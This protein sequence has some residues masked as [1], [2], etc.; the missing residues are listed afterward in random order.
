MVRKGKKEEKKKKGGRRGVPDRASKLRRELPPGWKTSDEDEVLRRRV[1]A[2][3]E[4]IEVR[5]LEPSMHVYGSFVAVTG[6]S[7]RPHRIELRSVDERE[8]TCDCPDFR[9]NGLGTC[10]HVEAV[11]IYAQERWPRHYERAHGRPSPL[12]EV[13]LSRDEDGNHVRVSWPAGRPTEA[14]RLLEPFFGASG[15][16]LAEPVFGVPAVR[17]AVTEFPLR[18]RARIRIAVD[19]DEWVEELNRRRRRGGRREA[20]LKDAAD[21]KRAM[22]PLP[23]R[24]YSYQLEGMLHLAFGERAMLA[25]DMGLGKTIQAIAAAELLRRLRGIERVL[26]VSPVSLKAEWEEQIARFSGMPTRVVMGTRQSRIQQYRSPVFFNL[27]NYEQVRNDV[28]EINEF[29]APDLVILDEAQRIKNWHT[30][31]AQQVKRLASPYAFVLTGT[32]LE[33]RIDELYSIVDFLDQQLLGPLFRFNRRFYEFDERGRPVGYRNLRELHRTVLP[34]MLR[35]RKTDVEDQLPPRTV[36]NYFVPMHKEQRVRYGEYEAVVAR[37]VAIAKKRPLTSMEME[38]LQQKLACMRMLCDTTYILDQNSRI[39]PKLAELEDVLDDVLSSE[40]TKVIIF[41]EWERMLQ[42]V[43][44]KLDSAGLGYSWHTGSVPQQKR[45][46]EINEFKENPD[47]RVFLSTDAGATGLNLQV[48]SVVINIDLPWNPARLEQ[49][50]ARC[51][52][53]FQTRAVTVI[54]LVCEDSIEHRMLGTLAA[55]QQ[56]ADGVLDGTGDLD[57]MAM[58]SGR[59]AFM[60]RLEE[61]VGERMAAPPPEVLEPPEKPALPP[62]EVLRQELAARLADRLLLL[63]VRQLADGR[64]VMVAVVD[65]NADEIAPLARRL[66]QQAYPGTREPPAIEVLDRATWETLRRLAESGLVTVET[67]GGKTLHRGAAMGGEQPPDSHARLVQARKMLG[68]MQRKRKMGGVLA[69]GGF[70]HEALPHLAETVETALRAALHAAGAED[71]SHTDRNSL[72]VHLVR[73]GIFKAE[74]LDSLEPLRNALSN[75]DELDEEQA[76]GL[77]EAANSLYDAIEKYLV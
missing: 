17:R 68:K 12:I 34:V 67:H 66:V 76:A 29:M 61:V 38:R 31:T 39:S 16:L 27:V 8:N 62:Q 48:A 59:S 10:K 3:S 46:H 55:K 58:P 36:N 5:P 69:A 72:E 65:T 74:A 14:R 37:L 11:L 52:R 13:Y 40:E 18:E 53:K 20:F 77:A 28:V 44:E 33:N 54:N 26:V 49:R 51:W 19:V 50:I 7:G 24:L 32:P 1:R 22:N 41:S 25:D 47:C 42:L 9:I 75:V 2:L 45:R 57:E 4:P 60:R 73:R 15:A 71:I 6:D 35:R 43:R 23:A 64:E 63:E 21:G 30:K 70:P 56:L